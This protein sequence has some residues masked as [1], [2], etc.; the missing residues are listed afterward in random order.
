MLSKGE[1]PLAHMPPEETLKE[2]AKNG[3]VLHT[4]IPDSQKWSAGLLNF[5]NQCLEKN[6]TSR[7]SAAGLL[8]HPFLKSACGSKDF[9]NFLKKAKKKAKGQK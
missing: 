1:P 2:I 9:A 6:P 4:H 8:K 7:P 3:I 5:L